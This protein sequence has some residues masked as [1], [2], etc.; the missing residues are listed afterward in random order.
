MLA[1]CH[2][3]KLSVCVSHNLCSVSLIYWFLSFYKSSY[4]E[5]S[6]LS[7]PRQ[8]QRRIRAKADHVTDCVFLPAHTTSNERGYTQFVRG[9]IGSEA[10][11]VCFQ[12]GRLLALWRLPLRTLRSRKTLFEEGVLTSIPRSACPLPLKQSGGCARGNHRWIRWREWRRASPYLLPFPLDPAPALWNCKPVPLL[13][14]TGE[15]AQ[16]GGGRGGCRWAFAKLKGA[17]EW[18]TVFTFA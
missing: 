17:I 16:W 8:R 12:G 6:R 4:I 18:K 9:L 11:R 14:P 10:C 13:F 5:S 1:F 3:A 7:K 15:S 2:S